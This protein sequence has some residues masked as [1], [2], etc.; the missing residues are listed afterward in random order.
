[1][2][3]SFV[4]FALLLL[5]QN[6]FCDFTV[7]DDIPRVVMPKHHVSFFKNHCLDCHDAATEEGS[8]NLEDISF[9]L[10]TIKTAE[11]WQKVLNVI[12]SGEMPPKDE[13]QPTGEDKA[14]FLEALSKQLVAARKLHS[15]SGGKITMRRLNRREYENSIQALLG[16]RIDAAD[17]PSD[18]N[19]GG[20]DTAGGSLFFS[21]DQ[22]EQYLK[23]AGKALD[24]AIVTGPKPET[25]TVRIEAEEAAN[26][27]VRIRFSYYKGGYTNW[28]QWQASKGKPPTDFGFADER[29]ADFRKRNW[30]RQA[31]S[32]ADYM[33]REETLTGA[34]LTVG[35]ANPQVG[36]AIPDAA[37][38]GK[39]RVRASVGLVGRPK[40]SETFVE[41]G[42]RGERIDASIGLIGCQQVRASIRKP[43]VIQFDVDIPDL[44]KPQSVDVGVNTG[45]RVV[46]GE[47]VIA[48]RQRQF[49]TR[50]A[51]VSRHEDSINKTGFGIEPT[52][53]IDWVEWEGPLLEQWPPV[54]H[55]DIFFG[56]VDRAKNDTYAK[57]IIQRF[58]TRAFR[59]KEPDPEFVDRL[60][61]LFQEQKASGNGFEEALKLPLS[62]VLASPGFL[63]LREPSEQA[64]QKRD[65]SN[66]E[67]AVRLSYFLWSA[68]PDKELREAAENG[69]LATTAGLAKQTNRLLADDRAMDF[70]AGFTHQWLDMERLDF[71]QFNDKLY[72][73]FD[74]S[75]KVAARQE[76]YQTIFNL[77]R[78]KK[79]IGELLKSDTIVINDLLADYY[80][81]AKVFGS[82]FR[83]VKV[84][85]QLPRGGLLGMTAILAMGSDGERSSP[86]ERGAWVLR[87]LLN[88]PPPP[89]PANVPQLSRHEGKLLPARKLLE[90]HMEEAQCS[91]CHRKIDPIGYGLEHFNAVGHWRETE[92]VTAGRKTKQHA[93]D[94]SGT[95]PDGVGFDGFYELR[96][97]IAEREKNFARGFVEHLVEYAL[98]R[99]YG[100]TDQELGDAI[101]A[102]GE[103]NGRKINAYIHAL[104][105]SKSFQRK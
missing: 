18:A 1:M 19:S 79:P 56:G 100:F 104:V 5:S 36:L 96:N 15:D 34:L 60:V 28:K 8:V 66:G 103:S 42:F 10:G 12:N 25:K 87:K 14:A 44:K 101:I 63:Y 2:R 7:A 3:S 102:R 49:N 45:K 72:P 55:E 62:I 53:W 83:E 24:Q 80:G 51:A 86:V 54:A 78:L 33:S 41:V 4:V 40:P 37:P 9:D 58:A 97:R 67:L 16:V 59:V 76:V 27:R 90:A 20:F 84:S 46:I 52:L 43:E 98:G 47:R 92:L 30:D 93:I 11:A 61:T 81:I 69:E 88:D 94:D 50:G 48:F 29:H 74:D 17:L 71:F 38:P 91:Q 68:P 95:M 89:A 77:I 57:D 6:V 82:R 64:E 73:D 13:Q 31:P 99:P 85:E 105:Q 70:V 23:L 39:Y 35:G 65:L 22:F 26:W 21:S 75:V 32:W